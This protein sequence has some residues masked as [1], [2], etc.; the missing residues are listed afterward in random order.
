MN[1]F[2]GVNNN[3]ITLYTAI[4]SSNGVS[5]ANKI[6]CTDSNGKINVNFLPTIGTSQNTLTTLASDN[7]FEGDF[8]NLFNN[9][10]IIN[11]RKA[12]A[13]LNRIAH[14][15]SNNFIPAGDIGTVNLKGENTTPYLLTPGVNC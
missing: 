9:G 14:G 4:S 2:L 13:L 11:I 6:L 12:D 5:D 7:I 3:D 8:I 15:F 1:K 10:G